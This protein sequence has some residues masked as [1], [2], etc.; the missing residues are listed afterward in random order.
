VYNSMK[1]RKSLK[2][3][4]G[5][6]I[7]EV[8][9]AA[10]LV[11]VVIVASLEAATAINRTHRICV[12]RTIGPTLAH[13][14]M[15]EIVSMPYEDPDDDSGSPGT[16]RNTFR[17]IGDFLNTTTEIVT[18]SGSS[19]E[20]YNEWEQEIDISW[21][22]PA[23]GQ[24]SASDTGLKRITVT[25]FKSSDRDAT[26]VSLRAY[27]SRNGLLEQPLYQDCTLIAWVGAE[28]QLTATSRPG[29]PPNQALN[30]KSIY[31]G[32]PILNHVAEVAEE[33]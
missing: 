18:R 15:S 27:R 13:S 12:E 16:V 1:R 30:T 3:Q 14:L 11:G 2:H 32:T 4:T 10:M 5:I 24:I 21:V 20:D 6:T 9:I 29:I 7:A 23:T 22:D 17:Q 8:G 19:I 31:F 26:E 28:L 25:V 33:E